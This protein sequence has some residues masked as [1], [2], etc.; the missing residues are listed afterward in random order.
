MTIIRTFAWSL[1]GLACSA[2]S[3]LRFS[4]TTAASKHVQEP[5]LRPNVASRLDR[6]MKDHAGLWSELAKR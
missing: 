3:F 2:A 6:L 4:R 5:S 1:L